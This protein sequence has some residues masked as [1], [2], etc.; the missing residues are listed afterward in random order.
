V[1][2]FIFMKNVAIL[3]F[4][5]LISSCGTE[6]T[7]KGDSSVQQKEYG[8]VAE[9][10]VPTWQKSGTYRFTKEVYSNSCPDSVV[11]E[12]L[13][14]IATITGND[15]EGHIFR[16]DN[17]SDRTLTVRGTGLGFDT[18]QTPRTIVDSDGC[19][20]NRGVWAGWEPFGDKLFGTEVTQ[21]TKPACTGLDSFSCTVVF[22][23]VGVRVGDANDS[24]NNST[25]R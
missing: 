13:S 4:T 25:E 20:Y 23:S 16:R 7:G 19:F 22:S 9:E 11:V 1:K 10:E 14:Y 24:P 21:I 17:H 6:Y 12:G 8:I 15:D 5:G 2:E 3:L 18:T